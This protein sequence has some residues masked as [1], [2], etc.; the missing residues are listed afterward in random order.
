MI[1]R[2]YVFN[3][4]IDVRNNKGGLSVGVDMFLLYLLYDVYIL[5]IKIDLKISLYLK[6]YN[7]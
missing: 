1:N 5:Y 2:E 4:V 3:L 6:W 7:E